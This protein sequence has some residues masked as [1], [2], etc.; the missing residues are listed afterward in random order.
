MSEQY[1]RVRDQLRSRGYLQGR[2]ER[3]VLHDLVVEGGRR[4]GALRPAARAALIGAPLLG[5]VLAAAA[6]AGNRP[7]IGFAD[8][9]WLWLYFGLLAAGALFVLVVAATHLVA[10]GSRRRRLRRPNAWRAAL[11]VGLPTLAYLLVLWWQRGPGSAPLVDGL[12]LLA[13]NLCALLVAWLAGMV[14]LANN[15]GRT[16]EVPD[17][18]RRPIALALIVLLPL[19]AGWWVA[20]AALAEGPRS[21]EPSAFEVDPG[22]ARLLVVAVDGLADADVTALA[23]EEPRLERW[24]AGAARFPLQRE[25]DREPAELWT[26]IATGLPPRRHGVQGAGGE[27]LPGV[28]TPLRSGR[29]GVPLAA[30]LRWLLPSRTVAISGGVRPVRTLW[31]IVGLREPSLA[32]GWW[33]SWPADQD[34]ASSGRAVVLSDRVLP[35]L[36]AGG[37][38]NRESAP[39]PLMGRLAA[40]FGEDEAALRA[41]FERAFGDFA[42]AESERLAWES[43]LIDAYRWQRLSQLGELPRL[44]AA[45]VYLPG[46]DILRGRG[47][48]GLPAHRRWLAARLA[49]LAAG[50]REVV[51]I[52]DPG[53]GP[54]G[55]GAVIW[56]GAGPCTGSPLSPLDVAPLLLAASGY[57]PSRE[58]PGGV[59]RDDCGVAVERGRVDSYGRRPVEAVPYDAEDEAAMVERL[60]SLGYL[61]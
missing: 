59:P 6:A 27:R 45:F 3:F 42:E 54:H 53:R 19:S 51:L 20:R 4:P 13:A 49:E 34:P 37:E 25:G 16:G 31:E 32:I 26:T 56:G 17:R 7:L 47:G 1:R 33:A 9:L 5:A 21:L 52:A 50:E 14:S 11:V 55:G 40:S 44:R 10:L 36:L 43:F 18:R 61:K 24:F 2:V 41:E 57:P 23:A 35:K 58:M 22:G 12:F 28:A 8:A 15:I 46:L 48:E 60:R 39:L 29:G 30:A 38:P